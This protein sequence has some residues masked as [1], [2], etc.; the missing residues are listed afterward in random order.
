MPTLAAM[1]PAMKN[2]HADRSDR[3]SAARKSPLGTQKVAKPAVSADSQRL[4]STHPAKST[5]NPGTISRRGPRL[6]RGA[7]SG[8]AKADG[9]ASFIEARLAQ[10]QAVGTLPAYNRAGPCFP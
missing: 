6:G 10:G 5:A 8:K 7:S 2:G 1:A 9:P 3:T 4:T